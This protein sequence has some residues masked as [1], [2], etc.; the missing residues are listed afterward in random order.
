[1]KKLKLYGGRALILQKIILDFR[2]Q[3]KVQVEK[4]WMK[5]NLKVFINLREFVA[6]A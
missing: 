3:A 2:E 5:A 4:Y 1:M 6:A